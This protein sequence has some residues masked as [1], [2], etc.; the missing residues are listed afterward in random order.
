ME[1]NEILSEEFWEDEGEVLFET[2]GTMG[3]GKRIL[4]SKR[5]L[6][7]SAEAVNAW[8]GVSAESVWGLALPVR[9]VG[10]FGVVARAAI[11][12]CELRVYEGKWNAGSF[13]EWVRREGVSH[14]SLVPT[15]VHDLV[16]GGFQGSEQL[17]AVVVGG[18]ALDSRLGQS[19]RDFDWP[20]LASYGMTEASSQVATQ[21]LKCLETPFAEG[22]MEIL[23]IWQG[24]TS[25]NGLLEIKGEAL[26]S[27]SMAGEK[28]V[29]REAEWFRTN[30]RVRIDGRHLVPLGRSDSLVKVM[31]ELVDLE[32][33]EREFL[34][35]A[36][37][38]L[39]A[40]DFAI[41]AVPDVRREHTLIAVFR[42]GRR[43]DCFADFQKTV[44]GLH[45]L[46]GCIEVEEIPVGELGKVRRGELAKM[47]R[48]LRAAEEPES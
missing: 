4:L 5:A 46:G 7:I 14:V 13:A 10:G 43:G 30:D 24:R 23:P 8:L 45:K 27:G 21:S 2:S 33:V 31:G 29:E 20:V 40:G 35:T 41:I 12:G 16:S 42:R 44:G 22:E 32:A 38:R 37:E 28:F 1:I 9:H 48:E 15:Q 39:T 6:R 34:Q 17:K 3:K 18:G 47:V 11:C 19:A 26:F 36:G 25:E